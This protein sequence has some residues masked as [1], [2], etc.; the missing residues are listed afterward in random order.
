MDCRGKFEGAPW[1]TQCSECWKAA[2]SNSRGGGPRR[3]PDN[4][5]KEKPHPGPKEPLV[6][7]DD[8]FNDVPF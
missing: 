8:F 7:Q 1:M 2:N 4:P 3:Q 5:K 6:P